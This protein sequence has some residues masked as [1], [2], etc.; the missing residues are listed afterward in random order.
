MA[1]VIEQNPAAPNVIAQE[2][3]WLTADRNHVVKEGDPAAAFL[4]A[5][6]GHTIP[7]A[8][9]ERLGLVEPHEQ[10]EVP[11][12]LAPKSDSDVAK[13]EGDASGSEDDTETE[14]VTNGEEADDAEEDEEKTDADGLESLSYREL[15][16][17]CKE[18]DV[19]GFGNKETLIK[20]L[21]DMEDDDDTGLAR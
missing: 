12:S 2:R 21:R 5:V 9:A 20:R 19:S 11:E 17:R 8:E 13:S 16:D 15:Q 18:A 14:I 7:R 1:L 4:L 3:L 10:P 6:P